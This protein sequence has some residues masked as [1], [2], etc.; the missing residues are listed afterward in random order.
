MTPRMEVVRGKGKGRNGCNKYG[1]QREI[2]A[3][4]GGCCMIL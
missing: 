1:K 2:E 4:N 3:K